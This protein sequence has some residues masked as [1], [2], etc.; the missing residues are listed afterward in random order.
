MKNKQFY[1]PAKKLFYLLLL[2]LLP[3]FCS[4]IFLHKLPLKTL[5][6]RTKI[7]KDTPTTFFNGDNP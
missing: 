3:L 2:L 6:R 4:F 7:N 1:D 5:K